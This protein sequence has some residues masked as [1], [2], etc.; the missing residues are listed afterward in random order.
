MSTGWIVGA[1]TC[2]AV[3]LPV[4]TACSATSQTNHEST[5]GR[6]RSASANTSTNSAC[7]YQEN[8]F[9]AGVKPP[10][11]V[12]RVEPD[13]TGLPTP[14]SVEYFI[15][16]IRIDANGQVTENCMLRGTSPE[17]N[18]RVLAAVRGWQF[19]PPRLIAGLDSPDGRWEAGAV[20]PIFATVSVRRG[21]QP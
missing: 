12:K 18:Q 4:L 17:A 14:Q 7:K 8:A 19:E 15:V 2:C 5:T 6:P 16:E 9:R 13:F 11:Q 20:V 1:L 10:R 3:A 21:R